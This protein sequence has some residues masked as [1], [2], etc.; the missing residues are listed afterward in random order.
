MHLPTTQIIDKYNQL[1]QTM[2]ETTDTNKLIELSKDHKKLEPKFVLSIEIEKLKKTIKENDELIATLDTD[3]D[4]IEL[5]KEE[6]REAMEKLPDLEESLLSYLAPEDPKDDEDI[7]LEIR[8]G[9]GGDEAS[10]FAGE[11]LKMYLALAQRKGLKTKIISTSAGT[12]GGYK[13]VI[14]EIRGD[15]AYAAFKYEG[16]VHRVQRVPATEKQGR[17]HTSTISVAIMPLIEGTNNFKL[18]DDEIEIM[19][20]T[21]SG[22]GGQSVNTTYSAVKMRHKP[23]GIEAQSQDEKNQIQNR[24]RCLQVLTSRVFDHYE[25]IRLAEEKNQRQEQV[26]RADRSEKIRTYNFPQDRLTDHRYG[27]N[28]NRLPEIMIGEIEEII[29]QINKIEAEKELANIQ[30]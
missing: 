13:E 3:D 28:W 25:Q 29:N 18:K 19:I 15:M 4:L 12:V 23:T 22:N 9:A 26:G 2:S 17:V 7:L 27:Q 30:V 10:I 20:T 14:I 24:E 21:A 5:A 16:G 11:V 8:A 6:N 1:N